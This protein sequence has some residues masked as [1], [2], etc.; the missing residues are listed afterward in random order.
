MPSVVVAIIV[1]MMRIELGLMHLERQQS[2][3]IKDNTGNH[4]AICHSYSYGS[5]PQTTAVT[6]RMR[7]ELVWNNDVD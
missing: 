4:V 6:V 3:A 5:L 7:I 2:K 1:R